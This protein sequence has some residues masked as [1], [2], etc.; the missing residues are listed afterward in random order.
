MWLVK[1]HEKIR[2]PFIEKAKQIECNLK[3]LEQEHRTQKSVEEV[4]KKFRKIFTSGNLLPPT[5][6]WMSG[7]NTGRK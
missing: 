7:R 5:D 1:F 4:K 2:K 6:F 3:Y